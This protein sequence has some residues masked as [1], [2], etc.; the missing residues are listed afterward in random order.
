[1]SRQTVQEKKKI[2]D[3]SLLVLSQFSTVALVAELTRREGVDTYTSDERVALLVSI[4]GWE[5][6]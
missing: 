3:Q 4:E 2:R 5:E 6:R 1:M